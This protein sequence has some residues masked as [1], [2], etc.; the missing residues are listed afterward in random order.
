MRVKSLFVNIFLM[1]LSA[2]TV[3]LSLEIIL[4]LFCPIYAPLPQRRQDNFDYYLE[5]N[6]EFGWFNKRNTSTRLERPEFSTGIH[7]NS[8]GL[9]EKEITYQKQTGTKRIVVLG[10]S[11]VFGFGVNEELAIP[12]R[13][14]ELYSNSGKQVEVIN[15]GVVGFGTAQELLLL[16]K[17][18]LKYSPDIVICVFY[19]GNDLYNNCLGFEYEKPKPYFL[20]NDGRLELR[21]YPTPKVNPS[22]SFPQ[23]YEQQ[24]KWRIPMPVIKD[25]LQGNSYAYIFLRVRYNYLLYSIGLRSNFDENQLMMLLDT[26]KAIFIEMMNLCNKN[27]IDFIVVLAPTKAQICGIDSITANTEFLAFTRNNNIYCIDLL[28][29]LKGRRDLYFNIDDHWNKGGHD[30]VARVLFKY[31]SKSIHGRWQQD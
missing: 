25:F 26:T 19:I 4:R 14:Q 18:G 3:L 10:D 23:P 22:V 30:F 31:L 8:N 2:F 11:M 27:N 16:K 5:Y 13:L 17:E 21:N 12:S 7:I 29:T 9:R 15:M 24:Q 1:C 28:P 20:L 6:S